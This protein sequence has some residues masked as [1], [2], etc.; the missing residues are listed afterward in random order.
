MNY[1]RIYKETSRFK[2]I[3]NVMLVL[4]FYYYNNQF[5]AKNIFNNQKIIVQTVR[6]HKTKHKLF[7]FHSI[8]IY[9]YIS[10]HLNKKRN[11]KQYFV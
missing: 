11:H 3:Y 5:N 4:F 8:I 10:F 9:I 2:T 6:K 1:F 7:I